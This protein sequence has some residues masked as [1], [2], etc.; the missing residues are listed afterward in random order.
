MSR[1]NIMTLLTA[2]FYFWLFSC[3]LIIA[4]LLLILLTY[5]LKVISSTA[6]PL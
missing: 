1:L 3:L 6:E 5:I 4:L 2:D